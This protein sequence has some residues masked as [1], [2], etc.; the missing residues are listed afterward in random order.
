MYTKK[1]TKQN[2]KLFMCILENMD[3]LYCYYHS[4]NMCEKLQSIETNGFGTV[5]Q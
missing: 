2:Y 3:E 1:Q 5:S 4:F